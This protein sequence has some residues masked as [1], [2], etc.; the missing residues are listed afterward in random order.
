MAKSLPCD[1]GDTGLIPGRGTKNPHAVG[2]QSPHEA[3]TEP[4][5]S[6]ASKPQKKPASYSEDPVQPK[7]KEND[8]Q[9]K[10]LSTFYLKL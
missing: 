7:E 6:G 5:C 2:Q 3:T 8:Y 1:E 9:S 4:V 10:N